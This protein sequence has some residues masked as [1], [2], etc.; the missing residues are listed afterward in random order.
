LESLNVFIGIWVG[1]LDILMDVYDLNEI[2]KFWE[3][4]KSF[5]FEVG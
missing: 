1:D 3:N 5:G 4:M 2:F